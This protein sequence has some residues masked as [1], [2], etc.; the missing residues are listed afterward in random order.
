MT[1]TKK[2]HLKTY[3]Y[4]RLRKRRFYVFRGVDQLMRLWYY[5][6][7]QYRTRLSKNKITKI[8]K[9][10]CADIS[11]QMTGNMLG[12]NRKTINKWFGI[13]RKEI[14][15]YQSRKN[16]LLT[17]VVE[18]DDIYFKYSHNHRGNITGTEGKKD[19]K[20]KVIVMVSRDGSI[21]VH[22]M[23]SEV[24]KH[25]LDEIEKRV[26]KESVVI[27]RDGD[28]YQGLK[29]RGFEKHVI[30]IRKTKFLKDKPNLC[31]AS[32]FWSFIKA[33]LSKFNGMHGDLFEIHL[34]E[35]EWRWKKDLKQMEK[36]LKKL[37]YKELV[38]STSV[39]MRRMN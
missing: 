2:S 20:H 9:H 4:Y 10:F 17:G 23:R 11:Q 5:E 30:T 39:M 37:L 16:E 36:E 15:D 8:I 32:T 1:A 26:D 22:P 34:K 31:L 12:M 27:T 14:Y 25:I 28:L 38:E 13:F 21:Y 33:R 24:Y 29:E 19:N 6:Y 3:S 18:I 35:S 7:M